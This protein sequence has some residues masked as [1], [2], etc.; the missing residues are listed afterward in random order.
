MATAL[1]NITR[2]DQPLSYP[3]LRSWLCSLVQALPPSH[4]VGPTGLTGAIYDAENQ[5]T[6]N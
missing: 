3:F 1:H 6:S 4:I 5:S 2:Q